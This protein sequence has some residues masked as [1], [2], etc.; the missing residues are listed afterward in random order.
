MSVVLAG[1]EMV[2][3]MGSEYTEEFAKIYPD[4][5]KAQDVLLIPFFLKGV[6]GE[7]GLNQADGIHPSAEGHKIIA[8]TVY[9]FVI[10]AIEDIRKN[11]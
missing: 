4:T 1:M 2:R 5:A 9:P 11:P 6:A 7:S 10:Q 3:N 8:D